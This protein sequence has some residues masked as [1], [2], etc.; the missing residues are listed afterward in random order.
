MKMAAI[1]LSE[2][3]SLEGLIEGGGCPYKVESKGD[4]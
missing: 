3:L 2:S 4:N 1:C